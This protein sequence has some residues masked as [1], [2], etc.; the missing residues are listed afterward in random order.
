MYGKLAPWF[1]LLTSP[2]DYEEE[3]TFY[4]KAIVAAA[5]KRPKTLLE[6]GSG[7]GNNALYMKKHFDMTLTDLSASMLKLSRTI[8]PELEHV[9][10]DMR[11]IRLR[12][13][14][15]AVFVHDA[16]CYMT[17]EADL[18]AAIET[19]FVHTKPGGVALFAPDYVRET[20]ENSTHC[21]GHDDPKSLRGL[22]Y[23]EWTWDPDPND[24]TYTTEYSFILRDEDGSVRRERDTHIDGLF[25]RKEWMTFLRDGGFR[26]KRLPFKHSELESTLEVFVGVRP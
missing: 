23:L 8:N 17:T 4:R 25:S 3:A 20:F 19:A 24:T 15:D 1:H 18:R 2:V 9:R 22:R 6:L 7:G 14:F 11:S 26:P 21:G 13:E 12:R 16:V 10:G 5:S